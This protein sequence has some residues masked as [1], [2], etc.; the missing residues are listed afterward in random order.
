MNLERPW[1]LEGGYLT[2]ALTGFQARP[3]E[4]GWAFV[5]HAEG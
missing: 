4:L 3:M 2:S 5:R 1:S